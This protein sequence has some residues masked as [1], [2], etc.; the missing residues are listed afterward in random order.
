MINST[1]NLASY[2]PLTIQD[3][4]I[5]LNLL[6]ILDG[7]LLDPD[8]KEISIQSKIQGLSG[9]GGN[10]V[11]N[12]GE[13]FF[14]GYFSGGISS[15]EIVR[16]M[17]GWVA[18]DNTLILREETRLELFSKIVPIYGFRGTKKG[19]IDLLAIL[20]KDIDPELNFDTSLSVVLNREDTD[21]ARRKADLAIENSPKEFEFNVTFDLVLDNNEQIENISTLVLSRYKKALDIISFV[22]EKNKPAYTKYNK[23]FLTDKA[24][25]IME[26]LKVR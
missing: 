11:N 18:L 21:Q 2:L 22:I 12:I 25:K 13:R 20:L 17:Y 6:S 3:D 23:E 19:M 1:K 10:K 4:V 7:F 15:N 16:W 24:D 9:R 5:I 14:N 8:K 26:I